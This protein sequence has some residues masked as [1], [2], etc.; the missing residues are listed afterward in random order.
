VAILLTLEP[1]QHRIG[2]TLSCKNLQTCPERQTEP[3]LAHSLTAY[4]ANCN[5]APV[6]GLRF[7]FNVP[8][9]EPGSPKIPLHRIVFFVP[10]LLVLGLGVWQACR[11]FKLPAPAP[12][13]PHGFHLS[14]D[15][16]EMILEPKTVAGTCALVFAATSAFFL[17]LG[18]TAELGLRKNNSSSDALV[19]VSARKFALIAGLVGY[20]YVFG[21]LIAPWLSNLP[22]PLVAL[23]WV[24]SAGALCQGILWFFR[25]K[26][27]H[28]I[29][30]KAQET[31][32]PKDSP[33]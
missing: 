23:I 4:S 1:N 8:P 16:S 10:G 7:R 2:S 5:V 29:G 28:G 19:F 3:L 12:G 18:I 15:L 24:I 11:Y 26:Q 22:G 25:K 30:E 14:L 33:V 27:E 6:S 32:S 20:L 31:P 13:E 17:W 21:F 9:D